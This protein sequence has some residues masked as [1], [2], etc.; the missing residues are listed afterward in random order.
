[1]TLA[2]SYDSKSE[3]FETGDESA[4]SVTLPAHTKYV[5]ITDSDGSVRL[6]PFDLLDD[7]ERAILEN[8][9]LYEAVRTGL[10][11]FAEGKSVSSDW[12]F[13]DDE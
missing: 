6:V 11:E 13:D 4:V 2:I 9:G 12:L 10:K 1:M 5:K 8:D 3:V 7:A